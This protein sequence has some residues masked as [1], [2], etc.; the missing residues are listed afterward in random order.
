MDR[1]DFALEVTSSENAAAKADLPFDVVAPMVVGDQTVGV[2]AFARPA[3]VHPRQKDMLQMIAQLGALAWHN[4]TAFRNVKFAAEV[5][6]LTGI[7]NKAALKLRLSELIYQSRQSGTVVSLFMF[8]ID[9][10]KN[11][12]DLNGHLA[13]DQLLRFLAQLVRDTVRSDDIF[14]RFGGEEFLLIMPSR[15]RD[16]AFMAAETIRERI[17]EYDFPFGDRQPLGMVSVSG[18]VATFPDDARDSV[19]LLLAAD[20]ALYRA[21]QKGRNKVLVA[22]V[23]LNPD[24]RRRP[25]P[26]V[27]P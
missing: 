21:K 9:H 14:G 4:V 25:G 7:Y 6:E 8:D 11:Y 17:A 3:R 18:G 5:D 20:A 23:G 1:Q 27:S 24:A 15:T 22:E 16:Q 26:S 2:V 10:F 13:G 19:D 12:N